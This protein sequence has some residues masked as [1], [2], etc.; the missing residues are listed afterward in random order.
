LLDSE[1][2][3]I[4]SPGRMAYSPIPDHLPATKCFVPYAVTICIV[5][6]SWRWA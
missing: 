3:N 5:S 4:P 1:S 6:S 2:S